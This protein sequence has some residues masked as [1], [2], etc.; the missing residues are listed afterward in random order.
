MSNQRPSHV[1]KGCCFPFRMSKWVSKRS[2]PCFFLFSLPLWVLFS[3]FIYLF[4]ITTPLFFQSSHFIA[5]I[6]PF[7]PFNAVL[8]FNLLPI[9]LI[10]STFTLIHFCTLLIDSSTFSVSF[11]LPLSLLFTTITPPSISHIL[12]KYASKSRPTGKGPGSS[13]SFQAR[14]L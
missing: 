13:T 14:N 1:D 6:P 4:F 2:E 3:L 12:N 11:T 8:S 9:P 7:T 10:P 5:P